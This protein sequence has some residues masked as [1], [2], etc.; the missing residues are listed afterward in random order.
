M[1]A[2]DDADDAIH[3]IPSCINTISSQD[4][5]V[6]FTWRGLGKSRILPHEV[7]QRYCQRCS[8]LGLYQ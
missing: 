7:N 8:H 4:R 2:E 3:V 5:E 1:V 6:V